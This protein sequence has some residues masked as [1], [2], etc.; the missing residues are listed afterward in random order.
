MSHACSSSHSRE[1][2]SPA[3]RA[4]ASSRSNSRAVSC[5]STPSRADAGDQLQ[6]R[7]RLGEV[8]VGAGLQAGDAVGD[9]A[10]GA[11]HQHRRPRVVLAQP[12]AGLEA[13]DA[14]KHDVED[15]DLR[16][17]LGERRQAALAGRRDLDLE[18]GLAQAADERAA[19]QEVVLDD[20]HAG[21]GRF[22]HAR[23]IPRQPFDVF[24]GPA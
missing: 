21:G 7:E 5:S 13:V 4:S 1:T 19:E 2:A 11:E 6:E 14:R 22:G 24:V 16:G 17:P 3:R 20:E 15:D 23:R 12:P 8:V 9:A 10:S 18:A